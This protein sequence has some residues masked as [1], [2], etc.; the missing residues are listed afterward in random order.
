MLPKSQVLLLVKELK[1]F[2]K[3]VILDKLEQ[4]ATHTHTHTHYT[5]TGGNLVHDK[6]GIANKREKG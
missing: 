3:R 1:K 5:H 6:Y 2:K 4:N